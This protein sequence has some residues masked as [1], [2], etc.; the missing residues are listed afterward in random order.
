MQPDVLQAPASALC[1]ADLICAVPPPPNDARPFLK[2]VIFYE[3]P[4]RA[5]S[6]R[7][8]HLLAQKPRR[9]A[10]PAAILAAFANL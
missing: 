8:L 6:S 9:E 4:A 5:L 10:C 7:Q 1:M 2:T 3:G